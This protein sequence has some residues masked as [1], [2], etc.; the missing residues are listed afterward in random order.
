MSEAGHIEWGFFPEVDTGAKKR[1]WLWQQG[2]RASAL[3]CPFP[4][5]KQSV[6]NCL[7]F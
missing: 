7:P 6:W 5:E 2:V 3:T 4:K 1:E